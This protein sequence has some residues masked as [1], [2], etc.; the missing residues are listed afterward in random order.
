MPRHNSESLQQLLRRVR[1][2]TRCDGLPLGPGPLLQGAATATILIAGQAPGRRAHER[3][4]PFDDPSGDRLR[5]WLG[6]DR[7]TFYDPARIAILPMGFCYPGTG[8]GGDL[9]PRSE[10]APAWRERLLAT[11][12][13]IRLTI[14]IGRHAQRWHLGAA[15]GRTLTENVANWKRFWPAMVPLPHPS[16]RNARWLA[17]NPV[18]EQTLLPAVR[19]RI[20]KLLG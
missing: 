2:C 19:R 3:G 7:E 16:P 5:A 12:P 17:R 6:I 11:M 14:L 20:E 1:R 4:I 13:A 8:K 9:P 10:C 15:G 18:V